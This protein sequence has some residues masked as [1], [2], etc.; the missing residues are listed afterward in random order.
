MKQRER[1]RE[2][3]LNSQRVPSHTLNVSMKSEVPIESEMIVYLGTP[4]A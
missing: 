2:R 3:D 4:C 1:E